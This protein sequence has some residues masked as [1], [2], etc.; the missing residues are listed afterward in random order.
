[1]GSAAILV[2]GGTEGSAMGVVA[3][4]ERGGSAGAGWDGAG[5]GRAAGGD[6][7]TGSVAIGLGSGAERALSLGGSNTMATD[8]G[9]TS[10]GSFGGGHSSRG[11]TIS[12]AS[13]TAWTSTEIA[14]GRRNR[15]GRGLRYGRNVPAKTIGRAAVAGSGG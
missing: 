10:S 7:G 5:A 8:A 12:S 3:G 4:A 13:T 2:G 1:M 6:G 9:N 15:T 11:P 14:A